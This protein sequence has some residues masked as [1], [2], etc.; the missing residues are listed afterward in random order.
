MSV[1]LRGR[2][3][4]VTGAANGIGRATARALAA[5]GAA[6]VLDDIDLAG[7]ES[8]RAAIGDGARAFGADVRR[9]DQLE[10]LMRGAV[11][12][13]GR[14]DAVV[15]C[16]GVVV[17]GAIDTSPPDAVAR[18]LETNLTGTINVVR[19]F[20]PLFRR[21]GSGHLVL[22]ASLAGMVPLPGES[23]Y[24]ATKFGVRGFALSL[25]LEL[26]RTGIRVTN[27]CPDSTRT[28]MLDIE[29]GEEGSSLSFASAPMAPEQVAAAVLDA[30]E[31]PRLE[32]TVPASRGRLI[33]LLGAIPF[34]FRP[35]YPVMDAMGRRRKARFRRERESRPV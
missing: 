24:A 13:W 21:Q 30:L 8:L 32:V 23:V 33:R 25:A 16:A 5:R 7:L 9:P 29:A 4:V 12:V 28:A 15:N 6:L 27:V 3:I 17:P 2:V 18:Q 20:L 31:R 14:V 26:R 11:A 10:E 19:A 1:T 22:V 35:L 34:I